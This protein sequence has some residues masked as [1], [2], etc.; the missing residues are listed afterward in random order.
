VIAAVAQ[1]HRALGDVAAWVQ[2]QPLQ[3]NQPPFHRDDVE[4]EVTPGVNARTTHRE[5]TVFALKKN[6]SKQLS[7]EARRRH[8]MRI[9]SKR[10]GCPADFSVAGASEDVNCQSNRHG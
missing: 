6:V 2:A 5:E 7:T 10:L 9:F 4:P 3:S 1:R 8:P